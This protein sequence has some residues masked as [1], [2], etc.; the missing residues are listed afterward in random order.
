MLSFSFNEW[1]TTTPP[2]TTKLESANNFS[3]LKFLASKSSKTQFAY[4]R[5]KMLKLNI[6]LQNFFYLLTIETN[7]KKGPRDLIDGKISEFKFEKK[8][9]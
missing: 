2:P 3:S 1:S 4:T 7:G 8:K 9:N 6:S 5:T